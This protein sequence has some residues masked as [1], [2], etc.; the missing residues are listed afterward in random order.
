M[1]YFNRAYV[2]FQHL[3]NF[4]MKIIAESFGYLP[5]LYYLC[6]QYENRYYH[7]ITGNAGGILQ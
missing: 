7:C 6:I 2:S 4:L 1:N 3:K 5:K